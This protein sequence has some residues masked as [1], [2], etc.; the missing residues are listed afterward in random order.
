MF[1]RFAVLFI[2][3]NERDHNTVMELVSKPVSCTQKVLPE[4]QLANFLIP[5]AQQF[6]VK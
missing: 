1:A 2:L 4:N 5:Y 6:V 3:R